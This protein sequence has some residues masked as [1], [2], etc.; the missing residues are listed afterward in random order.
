MPRSPI[1]DNSKIDNKSL[2]EWSGWG[3][4]DTVAAMDCPKCESKHGKNC[5]TPKGRK[6]WPPH[7]ARVLALYAAGYTAN[8][9]NVVGVHVPPYTF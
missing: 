6:T 1:T 8:R 3:F 4:T 9:V 7:L 5:R 2:A